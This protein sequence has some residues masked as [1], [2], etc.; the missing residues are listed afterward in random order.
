MPWGIDIRMEGIDIRMEGIDIRMEGIDGCREVRTGWMDGVTLSDRT[1]NNGPVSQVAGRG[2]RRSR[3]PSSGV[4]R[5]GAVA[6]APRSAC[7]SGCDDE[8]SSARA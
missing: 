3:R 7:A 6:F 8:A 1:G 5:V 4:P 2:S